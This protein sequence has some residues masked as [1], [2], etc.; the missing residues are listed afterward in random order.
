MAHPPC[1]LVD[2]LLQ[3]LRKGKIRH[4][5]QHIIQ[6]AHGVPLDGILRHIGDKNQQYIV[7]QCAD[8]AGGF[9]TVK[10]RHLDIQK[11]YVVDRAVIFENFHAAAKHRDLKRRA[12]LPRITLH[13]AGQLLLHGSL[14]LHNGNARHRWCLLPFL[15]SIAYCRAAA[16]LP[17]LIAPALLFPPARIF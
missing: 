12:V 13:I 11:N 17:K 6:R 7:I 1:Q 2:R 5:L 16:Q 8:A 10:V 4:G 15:Y 3:L 14:V 9:H